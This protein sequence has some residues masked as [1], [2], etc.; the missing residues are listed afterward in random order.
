MTD[1]TIDDTMIYFGEAVKALGDGKVGGYLVRF[2]NENERDLDGTYFTK[3][4]Y[5]GPKDGDGADTTFHHTIPIRTEVDG[6]YI[7]F[8]EFADRLFK[9]LKTRRDDIGIWAETVLDM[10]DKYEKMVYD[11]AT[12]GVIG[13]S[14]ASA[15]HMV[16]ILDNGEIVRW[17]IIEGALTPTPA[18]PRNAAVPLKSLFTTTGED[19]PQ[20]T[21]KADD[22]KTEAEQVGAGDI[23]NQKSTNHK[24]NHTMSKELTAA[25]DEPQ[26]DMDA[27]YAE[28]KRRQDEEAAQKAKQQEA[29]TILTQLDELKSQVAE[30]AETIKAFQDAPAKSTPEPI[31]GVPG[32]KRLTERGETNEPLKAFNYW[33][34]TGDKVPYN[35]VKANA[36]PLE[37]STTNAG[38]ENV[39]DDFL[40]QV[41]A[42]RDEMSI[43]RRVGVRIIPTSSDRIRVSTEGTS[44]S[45][46][47]IEGEGDQIEED[48]PGFNEVDI[49]VYHFKKR[50]KVSQ[51]QLADEQVSLLSFLNEA[52]GRAMAATEN[53]YVFTGAGTT[54]PEGVMTGGTLGKAFANPTSITKEELL[55]LYYSLPPEYADNAVW[56]TNYTTEGALYSLADEENWS[57]GPPDGNGSNPS[58]KTL[59]KKPIYNTSQIST[60]QASGKSMAIGDFFYYGLAE[61]LGLTVQRLDELYAENG[62]V[63]FIWR[64][65]MGGAV[66]QA[67]AFRYGQQST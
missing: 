37:S 11:L 8:E 62:Y 53:K 58:A 46:F 55:Q 43:A 25:P 13:W 52:V 42:K 40:T 2:T 60:M 59:W 17:P 27:L 19:T 18:E 10:H 54:E 64:F 61:R 32:I 14:S 23:E 47:A 65:R 50:M 49:D 9:P 35:A 6:K 45:V 51:E 24:E 39:P 30:Q 67:E 38:A 20:A 33:L 34:K 26:V 56:A 16:R 41:I 21:V 57:F 28:M 4:T 1:H 5:Y 22:A 36:Q 7:V 63:G 31:T 15:P 12:R 48:E 29:V 44:L 66:L 3:N